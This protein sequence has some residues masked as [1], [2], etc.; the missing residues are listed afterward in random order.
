MRIKLLF[1]FLLLSITCGFGQTSIFLPYSLNEGLNARFIYDIAQDPKGQLFIASEKG[2]IC[3]NGYKFLSVQLDSIQERSFITVI[4]LN[5]N[6]TLWVGNNK[7]QIWKQN[8]S[9]KFDRIILAKEAKSAVIGFLEINEEQMLIVTKSD[10]IFSMNPKD[11]ITKLQNQQLKIIND[12]TIINERTILIASNEGLLKCILDKTVGIESV[13]RLKNVSETKVNFIRSDSSYFWVGTSDEGLFQLIKEDPNSNEFKLVKHYSQ[14]ADY[15]IQHLIGAKNGVKWISTQGNGLIKLKG[16]QLQLFDENDGLGSPMLSSLFKDNEENLWIGTLGKGLYRKINSPFKSL[17]VENIAEKSLNDF[18]LLKDN[19]YV[20]SD[21]GVLIS[22]NFEN[23]FSVLLKNVKST[24]ICASK[25]FIFAACEGLGIV[26]INSNGK[27][28]SLDGSRDFGI[29]NHLLYHEN[30]LYV[31]TSTKGLIIYSVESSSMDFYNT[32]NG[33]THNEVNSCFVDSRNRIWLSMSGAVLNTIVN[34]SV[35]TFGKNEGLHPF[36]FSEIKEDGN[37]KIWIAS[38]GGG[39]YVYDDESFVN[40]NSSN[41]LHTNYLNSLCIDHQNRVW[42]AGRNGISIIDNDSKIRSFDTKANLYNFNVNKQGIKNQNGGIYILSDKGLLEYDNDNDIIGNHRN[43]LYISSILINDSLYVSTDAIELENGKYSMQVEFQRI[44]FANQNQIRYRYYLDGQEQD[45]GPEFTDPGCYYA[46]LLSGDQELKI[47]SSDGNNH[48]DE[49]ALKLKIAIDIPFYQKP[50]FI[51][52]NTLG[53]L[54]IFALFLLYRERKNKNIQ[55]YLNTEL[56]N[57]TKEVRKQKNELAEKNKEIKDSIVYAERIQKSMLPNPNYLKSNTRDHFIFYRPRD[58]VSGDF[59]W[60]HDNPEYFIFAGADCTGHGVP[61]SMMSMIC[62]S[63]LN[64]TVQ[65]HKHV[66]P[67]MILKVVDQ[68]V[69]EALHQ[70]TD[71]QTSDGMDIAL[72]VLSKKESI[73]RF[74]GA[75]RP[76]YYFE[77]SEL[78]EIKGSRNHI[79][80]SEETDKHFEVHAIEITEGSRIY[81]SSDGLVDQ[82]GGDAGKKFLRKRYRELLNQ[83]QSSSMNDQKKMVEE[84]FLE[85]KREQEQVDDILV[86]GLEF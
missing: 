83:I 39:L 61:G 77:N 45:Y 14:L 64:K 9:N 20:A 18:F 35:R 6:G 56:D 34:G 26:T 4:H 30:K 23:S 71:Q 12:A 58:I 51:A 3:F 86:M 69:R 84:C 31:S 25:D 10:G 17:E 74:S 33:L 7:G 5:Q 32:Q 16:N 53:L 78:K 40:Y 22:K 1:N 67:G 62:I 48:W 55:S 68:S 44:S 75:G 15:N 28:K 21:N 29:I 42:C 52:L 72:C 81:L 24:K 37:S 36:N 43:P 8:E 82:F 2:L 47:I 79:G 59:Y 11:G 60:F 49:E 65:V 38:D 27:H 46:G 80:G 66:D 54:G 13:Q 57:R 50:M 85:W 63:E 41:G 70:N 19:I 76:L 73:L